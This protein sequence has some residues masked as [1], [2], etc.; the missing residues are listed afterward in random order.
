[1]VEQLLNTKRDSCLTAGGR[2]M[3]IQDNFLFENAELMDSDPSIDFIITHDH[4]IGAGG[5][6]K[7]FKV[8]RR[9]DGLV[10]ALKFCH[11]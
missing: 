10:C 5:F 1:M 6:G 4:K 8:T 3:S 9:R 7:V 11:P 2:N